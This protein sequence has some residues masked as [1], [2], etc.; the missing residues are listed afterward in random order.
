MSSPDKFPIQSAIK[1]NN[2]NL[3][4]QLIS[5]NPRSVTAKDED[6]RTPLH[7][8]VSID[9]ANLVQFIIDHLPKGT[10]I[11][12]F[13][14]ASGWT[15][16]HINASIGNVEILNLLMHMDPPPDVNLTTNQGTTA[17]HLSISKNHAR[18]VAVLIDEFAAS[19]RVKDKMGYTPLH[20]AAS[21]GSIGMIAQLLNNSAKGGVNVN[22][23]DRDGW[24][25]L[26]HALAEGHADAAIY[27]VDEGGADLSVEN[28]EGKTPVEVAVDEKVAKYFKEHVGEKK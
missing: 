24:T 16:L 9:N 2:I 7:W 13:V 10:D 6:E 26:H 22:A 27:L 15:P 3:A 25:S 17:L 11:D 4:K 19:C 12:D 5:E 20:R 1:D 28:D 21:I 18:Y 8:A 14:D 23:K